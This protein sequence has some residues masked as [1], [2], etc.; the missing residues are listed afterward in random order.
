MISLGARS[1]TS[2][3]HANADT[4]YYAYGKAKVTGGRA[5]GWLVMASRFDCADPG[6]NRLRFPTRFVVNLSEA[7]FVDAIRRGVLSWPGSNRKPNS[8]PRALGP[9]D[10]RASASMLG[11][12][13]R[14]LSPRTM[15]PALANL[16]ASKTPWRVTVRTFR[17]QVRLRIFPRS[18]SLR[19]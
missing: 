7:T 9:L 19:E 8:A 2:K 4:R 6:R 5:Y 10:L 11:A 3:T 12:K 16:S 13:M 14:E 18:D 17:P 1:S 15:R